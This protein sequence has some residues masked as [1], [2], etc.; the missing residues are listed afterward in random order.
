[1]L[2]TFV[3]ANFQLKIYSETV[4][5]YRKI[6]IKNKYIIRFNLVQDENEMDLLQSTLK[7]IM[8]IWKKNIELIKDLDNM[9]LLHCNILKK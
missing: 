7:T 6:I 3:G 9:F 8:N 2:V 5:S 4:K 1:M